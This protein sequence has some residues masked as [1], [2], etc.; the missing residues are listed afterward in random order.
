[1]KKIFKFLILKKK[2]KFK[3]YF[4]FDLTELFKNFNIKK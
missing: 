1:M 2:F 4:N 3:S